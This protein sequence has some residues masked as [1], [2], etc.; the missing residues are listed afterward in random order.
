MRYEISPTYIAEIY[1]DDAFL[2]YGTRF[3]EAVRDWSW[4][5]LV[6]RGYLLIIK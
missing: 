1:G 6:S 2:Y 4:R 3:I 5:E